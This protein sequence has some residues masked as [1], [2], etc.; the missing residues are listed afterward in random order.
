MGYGPTFEALSRSTPAVA[1]PA[2]LT[3]PA[4]WGQQMR[5][6][7]TLGFVTVNLPTAIGTKGQMVEVERLDSSSNVITVNPFAGQTI[8]GAAATSYVMAS[9]LSGQNVAIRFISNG[10]NYDLIV[11]G[12][13]ASAGVTIVQTAHGFTGGEDVYV[14]AA[15]IL[16]I[17]DASSVNKLPVGWI[18]AVTDVNTVVVS[19]VLADLRTAAQWDARTEA[20]ADRGGGVTKLVAGQFYFDSASTVGKIT[21]TEPAN[22]SSIVGVALADQLTL[23]RP[24]GYRPLSKTAPALA[25]ANFLYGNGNNL[26]GAAIPGSGPIVFGNVDGASGSDIAYNAATGIFTL[27]P[28]RT[29]KLQAQT[30]FING[31][32]ASSSQF[33][34]FNITAAAYIGAQQ[35]VGTNA[36]TNWSVS[37]GIAYA[38]ITPTVV[39]QVSFAVR[40]LGHTTFSA[41]G[42]AWFTVDEV[43][44]SPVGSSPTMT[45]ATAALAGAVGYAPAPAAAAQNQLLRGDATYGAA[46]PAWVTA[47]NY[48][49]GD[50]VYNALTNQMYRCI[51]THVSAA[52]FAADIANWQ[53]LCKSATVQKF[54]AGG[55]YTPTAGMTYCIAEGIGSGGSSPNTSA[56]FAGSLE[57]AGNSGSGG[58]FKVLL[59]AAQIGVSQ[60][61]TIAAGAAAPAPGVANAPGTAGATTSLGALASATGGAAGSSVSRTATA[62]IE[63][64]FAL[65]SAS[66]IGTVATGTDLG[67]RRSPASNANNFYIAGGTNFWNWGEIPGTPI[68]Y[69]Q[70]P[71]NNSVVSGTNVSAG[72]VAGPANTGSGARGGVTIGTG[73]VANGA[74]GGSGLMVITEYFN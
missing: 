10:T 20:A 26:G 13:A 51:T 28:G 41:S 48:T 42:G 4:Q 69:G 47:T 33:Q 62:A 66:G 54:L 71:N 6:D 23:L 68:T 9:G 14:T 12:G 50:V 67:S 16:G 55:T 7:A 36:S 53:I 38:A 59:T 22:Y 31:S 8:G 37:D 43:S 63:S 57:M 39:T 30:G 11:G 46:V 25:G 3:I 70:P 35:A 32:A 74:A 24:T 44:V 56:G 45:G 73:G 64:G 40:A 5:A 60:A 49:A 21:I 15:G 65:A 19:G 1:P 17:A 52:T 58:Y 61:V 29:Y 18:S 72:G 34:W 2:G 27:Q